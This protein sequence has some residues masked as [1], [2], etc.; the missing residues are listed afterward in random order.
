MEFEGDD[1]IQRIFQGEKD[2]I[3]F[4]SDNATHQFQKTF[5]E[6][7]ESEK[8]VTEKVLIFSNSKITS[9]LGQRLADFVG[10]KA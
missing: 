9:G 3:F 2:T 10:A 1:A 8:K 6:I 7:A 4:F 5:V